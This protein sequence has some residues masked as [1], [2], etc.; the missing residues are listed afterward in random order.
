[1]KSLKAS[2][3]LPLWY[4]EELEDLGEDDYAAVALGPRFERFDWF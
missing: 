1:M 4:L 2:F 3:S